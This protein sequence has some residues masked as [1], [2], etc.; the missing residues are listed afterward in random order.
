MSL[1]KNLEPL[2]QPKQDQPQK[3]K[4]KVNEDDTKDDANKDGWL[5]I[6]G[7]QLTQEDKK[8][9]LEGGWLNDKQIHIVH[10]Y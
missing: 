6:S 1:K 4:R 7:I 3:K 8:V 9:L 5:S 10:K 2:S